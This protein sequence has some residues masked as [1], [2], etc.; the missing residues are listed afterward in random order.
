[1]LDWLGIDDYP[2][3]VRATAMARFLAGQRSS[4]VKSGVIDYLARTHRVYFRSTA[5]GR[6]PIATYI[7]FG[8]SV[9]SAAIAIGPAPARRASSTQ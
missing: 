8:V 2:F 7:S 6:N 5:T 9:A 4:R 1:M 3:R